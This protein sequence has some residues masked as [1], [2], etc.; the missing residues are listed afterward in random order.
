MDGNVWTARPSVGSRRGVGIDSPV[1]AAELHRLQRSQTAL[2]P[3]RRWVP[4]RTSRDCSQ[5]AL[6]L[7]DHRSERYAMRTRLY[8]A[9]VE[10]LHSRPGDQATAAVAP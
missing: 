5:Q 10:L 9:L 3:W 6:K 8:Q 4:T 1:D 2:E 7:A